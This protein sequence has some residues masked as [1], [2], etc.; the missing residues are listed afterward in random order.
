MAHGV[1]LPKP[2]PIA[3]KLAAADVAK[4]QIFFGGNCDGCHNNQP[5]KGQGSKYGP[6][7][8]EVIGRDKASAPEFKYSKTLQDWEGA[9]TYEDL[10]IFLYGP[11]PYTTPGVR[12]ETAGTP[13]DAERIDLIA[14]LRTLSDKPFC[15]K[16][17]SAAQRTARTARRSRSCAPPRETLYGVLDIDFGA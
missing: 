7:L 11:A 12:M 4:G 16:G 15:P 10:N 1:V 14:Y 3:E 8:W 5:G 6:N 13:D 2:A 9:W 17:N